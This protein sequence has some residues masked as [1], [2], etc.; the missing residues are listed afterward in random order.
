MADDATANAFP[1]DPPTPRA[2]LARVAPRFRTIR[3]Q[4]LGFNCALWATYTAA[5]VALGDA[6]AVADALQ[7]RARHGQQLAGTAR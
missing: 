4:T 5:E 6:E 3:A 1:A 2:L 7:I